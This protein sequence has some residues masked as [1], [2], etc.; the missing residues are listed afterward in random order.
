MR[1]TRRCSRPDDVVPVTV[2]AVFLDLECAELPLR[3]LLPSRVIPPVEAGAN[4]ETATVRG[5]RDQ[6]HD[7]FVGAQR[8]ATPVDRDE[9]E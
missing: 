8:A 3:D 2:E 7:G 5:V 1:S 4:N 6:T 9:R